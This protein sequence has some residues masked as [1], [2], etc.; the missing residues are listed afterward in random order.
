[1][2]YVLGSR[3]QKF[4]LGKDDALVI[5]D[6]TPSEIVV[7]ADRN[8]ATN[9]CQLCAVLEHANRPSRPFKAHP[10]FSITSTHA[11]MAV[12][13][14]ASSDSTRSLMQIRAGTLC[15]DCTGSRP[16]DV[17]VVRAMFGN[18]SAA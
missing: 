12:N 18:L 17:Y 6:A 8:Y 16:L 3:A 2:V 4:G 14:A 7:R 13:P 15:R 1:M 9:G 11:I 10:L 5:S